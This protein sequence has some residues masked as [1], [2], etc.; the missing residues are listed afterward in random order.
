MTT[1]FERMNNKL[2]AWDMSGRTELRSRLTFIGGEPEG[3][4]TAEV[5]L[6]NLEPCSVVKCSTIFEEGRVQETFEAL[7]SNSGEARVMLYI[8]RDTIIK[9]L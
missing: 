1:Q 4:I 8:G 9:V 2:P 3:M 7:A 6:I 5:K